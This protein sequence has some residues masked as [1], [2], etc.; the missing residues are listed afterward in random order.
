MTYE[1]EFPHAFDD[2]DWFEIEVKGW[3][4]GVRV[5]LTD[6]TIELTIYDRTRLRQTIDDEVE[7]LGFFLQNRLL[8]VK[9]VNREEITAAVAKLADDGFR[10]VSWSLRPRRASRMGRGR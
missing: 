1:I 9:A 10:N 7:Q 5:V 6:R 3:L 4:A 8:V 2:Y